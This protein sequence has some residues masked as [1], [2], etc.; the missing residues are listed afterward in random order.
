MTFTNIKV[1]IKDVF[2]FKGYFDLLKFKI[3]SEKEAGKDLEQEVAR[4][5]K[6]IV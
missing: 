3:V 1:I 5:P 2:E 4:C 6:H